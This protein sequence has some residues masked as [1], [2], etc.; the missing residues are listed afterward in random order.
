MLKI[1]INEIMLFVRHRVADIINVGRTINNEFDFRQIKDDAIGP[2]IIDMRP[3][4]WSSFNLLS[5]LALASFLVSDV[6]LVA[7]QFKVLRVS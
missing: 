5:F 7:S 4:S 6:I 1:K 3:G 2:L